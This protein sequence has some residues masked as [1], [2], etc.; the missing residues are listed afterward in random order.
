MIEGYAFLAGMVVQIVVVSLW[1]PVWYTK[2]ARVK[3]EKYRADAGNVLY[4]NILRLRSE[5][6]L[7]FY[8]A[9]NIVIAVIGLGLLTWLSGQILRPD[10]DIEL[11]RRLL[12]FFTVAQIVPFFLV[13]MTEAWV[14]KRAA[15][16]APLE[17]KRTA[18]L[19]R[20]SLFDFVSPIAVFAAILAYLLFAAAMIYFWLNPFPDFNHPLWPLR[21]VTLCYAVNAFVVYYALYGKKGAPLE[22]RAG[23]L[24]EAAVAANISVYA[25]I[26][27]VVFIAI[28]VTLREL[29]HE[30]R[31]LPFAAS[32]FLVACVLVATLPIRRVGQ[33][34]LNALDPNPAS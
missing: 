23:R 12:S 16:L 18:S 10:W 7:T 8:R 17:P 9:V 24:R 5:T 6:F 13:C 4:Q 28:S 33:G 11:V 22:T 14:H 19:Q 31:W 1:Q 2:Y 27:V 21:A 3:G 32:V 26:G 29:L 20:R 34:K 30:E 15:K 25:S